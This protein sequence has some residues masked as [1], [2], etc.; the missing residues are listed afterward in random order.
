MGGKISAKS[1]GI[2][3][4]SEFFFFLQKKDWF[5]IYSNFLI[6]IF[7]SKII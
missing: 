6:N 4:G 1:D 5:S 2:N 3:K 7:K